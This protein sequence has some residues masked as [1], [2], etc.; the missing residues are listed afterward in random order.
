M[1]VGGWLKDSSWLCHLGPRGISKKPGPYSRKWSDWC[2]TSPRLSVGAVGGGVGWCLPTLLFRFKSDVVSQEFSVGEL[3]ACYVPPLLFAK[4]LTI[5]TSC[6]IRSFP[7]LSVGY[8]VRAAEVSVRRAPGLGSRVVRGIGQGYSPLLII[9]LL[10]LELSVR[11]VG[12]GD[13]RE[14]G[15]DPGSCYWVWM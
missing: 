14:R 1:E 7:G 8:V 13:R 15:A 6:L 9:L 3:D 10:S 4:G 12:K 11:D 2:M 5:R